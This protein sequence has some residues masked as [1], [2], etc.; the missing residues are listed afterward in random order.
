M[1]QA[2]G[3]GAVQDAFFAVDDR[4]FAVRREAHDRLFAAVFTVPRHIPAASLLVRA[5]QDTDAPCGRKP[6]VLKRGQ[7][8]DC[9]NYRAFVIHCAAAVD[10]A[11]FDLAGKR[12]RLAPAVARGYDVQMR[13]HGDHFFALAVFAPAHAA[14]QIAGAEAQPFTQCE[15]FLQAPCDLAAVRR[16]VLGRTLDARDA[17][18]RGEAFDEFVRMSA[19]IGFAVHCKSS[20]I[21]CCI[22]LYITVFATVQYKMVFAK[23][24]QPVPLH[25]A[26][27]GR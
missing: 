14:V 9:G 11:V 27:L 19:E 13:E 25:F 26:Q 22:M 17:D 21:G 3:K 16:T 4:I 8:V 20:L 7:R 24:D 1:V 5:E 23:R 18:E 2:A 15:R 6:C 10:T 12:F